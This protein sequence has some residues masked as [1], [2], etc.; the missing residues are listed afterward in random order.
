MAQSQSHMTFSFGVAIL[1]A[2]YGLY[3]LN[4]DPEQIVLAS[5]IVVFAGML[6]DIDS[7]RTTSAQEFGGI[8]AAISPLLVFEYFPHLQGGG[9]AR[10]ALIVVCCYLLTKLLV[11]RGLQAFTVHR[12][13]LHSI[14]ASIL[15]FEVCFLLFWDSATVDRFYL[16][17][18]AFFG[19]LSH[20]LLDAY[21]NLDIVGR[22]L[23]KGERKP[24]VLKILG[25]TWQST[26]ILYGA[27]LALG[28]LAWPDLYPHVRSLA[29]S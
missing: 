26:A 17:Y 13:M 3:G 24:S 21:G 18:A 2:L 14:P 16:S 4:I 12:G 1:Y 7:G 20:L 9:V 6:P 15:V 5:A 23:G 25:P 22:A 27:I 19:F 8:L 10:I 28:Y 11:V 29:F